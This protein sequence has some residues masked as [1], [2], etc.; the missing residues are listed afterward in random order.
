MIPR[1]ELE[2]DA[3]EHG[4]NAAIVAALSWLRVGIAVVD[5][6]RR[7]LSANAA[8][9][10]TLAEATHFRLDGGHIVGAHQGATRA[11][12]AVLTTASEGDI[13]AP[14]VALVSANGCRGSALEVVAI[15]ADSAP[16]GRSF[17]LM[18]NH[19]R[20]AHTASTHV[21]QSLY[22]LT[23]TEA[24][25]ASQLAR[26]SALDEAAHDLGIRIATARTHLHNTLRK[27]ATRRQAELV[28]LIASSLADWVR[29]KPT[30]RPPSID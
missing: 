13:A 12:V 10:E 29:F 14:S 11:L 19:P 26:G 28:G 15:A 17:V 18:F 5:P 7:L 24:Q 6:Q 23:T 22:R 16:I 8:A 25:L 2:T 4:T 9:A 21:L 3:I 20:R 1:E 27:T 30:S